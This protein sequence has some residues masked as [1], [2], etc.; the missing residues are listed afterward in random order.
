MSRIGTPAEG[1]RLYGRLGLCYAL[2]RRWHKAKEHYETMLEEARK[3]GDREQQWEALQQ[4]AM[5]G[6]DYTADPESDDE[7][8]RGVKQ[9]AEQEAEDKYYRKYETSV[10]LEAFEWSPEY[11]LSRVEEA[12]SLA[13]QMS[14]DD[15]VASSLYTSA[16][17]SAW[18]GRWE[19]LRQIAD[20]IAEAR[21]IYATL[22]DRIWEGETLT[23][24]AWAEVFAGKPGEAQ[25][26]G[27]ERLF[28]G[29][30]T[31]ERDIHLA[32]S[33]G[34]IL[35]LLET[36]EYE[37]A[38]S[39]AHRGAEAARSLGHPARSMVAL[40]FLGDAQRS[41]YRL[42]EARAVYV[43]MSG[44][45]NLSQYRALVR[46]KLCAAAV[47]EG[48]WEEARTHALEAAARR[49]EVV[50]QLTAP[51][52]FHLEVEALLRGGE[53]TLAR[54]ELLRFGEHVG[55]SPRL[56]VSY[57][58]ARA[59]LGRWQTETQ[60]AIK[61]LQEAEELAKEI[62]LPGE[63]WQIRAGLGELHEGIGEVVDAH[64][65]FAGAAEGLRSLAERIGGKGL[66]TGFLAAPQA[67]QVLEKAPRAAAGGRKGNRG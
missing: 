6:T 64:Q 60:A 1:T 58:R 61:S 52:H 13:R 45:I 9:K 37:E 66:K 16:L 10:E 23:L 24:H 59:L 50:L 5:L 7:L 11:A 29:R 25:R 56:R 38:L 33:H 42:E 63:L 35:A 2:L 20:K 53:E 51:L 43:E 39:V 14:R 31:G 36:G 18:A 17:A 65:A 30:E 62:G 32:D 67:R 57:L 12:L 46:S 15:L 48:D 49:G 47:L 28:I 44:S 41:L 19:Y 21:Q 26:L 54:K 22:G 34:L 55:E 40:G 27:R 4:L 3:A 8:F